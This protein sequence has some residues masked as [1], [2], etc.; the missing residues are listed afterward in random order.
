MNIQNSASHYIDAAKIRL[1]QQLGVLDENHDVTP[2]GFIGFVTRLPVNEQ[3]QA[4]GLPL[5]LLP[6][7]PQNQKPE[8][9]AIEF[10]SRQKNLSVSGGYGESYLLRSFISSI[11]SE[12][13][14]RKR[15]HRISKE[16]IES[17]SDRVAEFE[18][19]D[20]LHLIE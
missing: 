13:E 19:C 9:T 1:L 12:F 11:V 15:K 17:I 7:R 3:A 2:E 16:Q 5:I 8:T 10:F 4:L 18:E 20:I 6:P 14:E